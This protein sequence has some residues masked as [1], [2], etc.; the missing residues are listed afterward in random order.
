MEFN[1]NAVKAGCSIF[2]GFGAGLGLLM[3]FAV[4]ADEDMGVFFVIF[5]LIIAVMLSPILSTIVGAIIAKDFDDE[6]DAAFNGAI[7]GAIGTVIMLFIMIFFFNMAADDLGSGDSD[8]AD[9][10]SD[11]TTDMIVKIMIPCAVGGALGAFVGFRYLWAKM[12]ATETQSSLPPLAPPQ[13]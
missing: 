1:E 2:A 7:V 13:F 5:G 12:P 9:E 3:Y 6:S 11:G 8:D 10:M 4:D